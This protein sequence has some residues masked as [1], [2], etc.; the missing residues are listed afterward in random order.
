MSAPLLDAVHR[1]PK[2]V[3]HDHLDGGLRPA[4]VVELAA[5]AGYRDLP[6][7]D[8]DDLQ[9]WFTA[10]AETGD[11]LA[12]LATFAHTVGVMQTP[13]AL[14][15]V[16]AEAALDLA[17]DGVRYA[18]VRFAP[19][20][21]GERGLSL[22]AVVDAAQR[23]FRRGEAE[24]A[25]AGRPIT[26]GTIVCAMRTAARSREVAEL[27]LRHRDAG[28]VGFDLAG[29]ETGYPPSDHRDALALVVAE[30]LHLTVHASEPPGPE[31]IADAL[32]CGAERIGHGVR[33]AE[34]IAVGPDGKARLGRLA[35][36]VRDRQVALE[37]C[38]TCNVQIGAVARLADH[39]VG[40]LHRLGF[41]ATVNTD[42]R[43]MSKV[44]VSS[45]L[46]AVAEA[47]GL[48]W[49]DLADLTAAAM[50]ASFWPWDERRRLLDEVIRPGWVALAPGGAP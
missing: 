43:L 6:T 18:E 4:T 44:S 14:E 42:N 37:L 26:V 2:V 22:D 33:I 48:T 23:G 27:A 16:A 17:A 1:A 9:A 50:E 10:G 40:L 34:D 19:E 13:E 8:P 24:A 12:Y 38:P 36:Y 32:R 20:L 5:E 35:A 31:L 39:P 25:A 21:H 28:V 47:Q 41:R 46:H 3:L 45:E 11:I 49:A 15:R 7:T 30:H 29:A